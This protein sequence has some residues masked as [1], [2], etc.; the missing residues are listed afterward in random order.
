[1]LW[2][3]HRDQDRKLLLVERLWCTWHA[4]L[5]KL[6]PLLFSEIFCMKKNL[7]EDLLC[8]RSMGFLLL[9]LLDR[10]ANVATLH[11]GEEKM[12]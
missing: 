12:M 10:I 1:M 5:Q 2:A 9:G 6:R 7:L 11:T 8:W 3:R 4:G